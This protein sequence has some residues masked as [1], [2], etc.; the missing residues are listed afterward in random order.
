MLCFHSF[1]LVVHYES[2]VQAML[3]EGQSS[4]KLRNV[5]FAFLFHFSLTI[6]SCSL[7]LS[8]LQSSCRRNRCVINGESVQNGFFYF[9][10]HKNTFDCI[11]TH[12]VVNS[13]HCVLEDALLL[14]FVDLKFIKPAIWIK[15]HWLLKVRNRPLM[16]KRFS[17][18]YKCAHICF[19]ALVGRCF[20]S[21]CVEK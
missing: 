20:S 1:H 10:K 16:R 9:W 7:V 6:F 5:W 14:F 2:L 21:A 19:S 15:L 13:F 17:F 3:C 8:Q 11:R 18:D 12:V 4:K